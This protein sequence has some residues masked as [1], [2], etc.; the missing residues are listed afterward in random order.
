MI[1]PIGITFLILLWFFR[2]LDNLLAPLVKILMIKIIGEP[3]PITGLG[4][5]I[6]IILVFVVGIVATNI[7]GRK[8]IKIGDYIV[9]QIPIVRN[10]Y[11]GSKQIIEAI[12]VH[13]EKAFRDAVLIEYPRKGI[14]S[15]GLITCEAKGDV[16]DADEEKLINIFVPTTPNPTSGLLIMVPESQIIHLKMSAEEAV[17]YIVS[18]GMLAPDNLK[19]LK[20]KEKNSKSDPNNGK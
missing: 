14:Y 3:V 8:L 18:I 13:K 20:Q 6:G 7:L 15:I 9:E 11:I 19:N 10:I 12:T 4:F 17:K 5:L 2:F 16:Q 1:V